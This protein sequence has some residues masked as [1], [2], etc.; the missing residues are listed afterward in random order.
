MITG[1]HCE[2]TESEVMQVLKEMINEIGMDFGSA[3][4]ECPAKP[5]THAFI[6]FMNDGER[7]KFIRSANMLKKEL[8]GRKI[9]ITRSM[10][11][12][13]RFYNKRMGYV[14]YCIHT[15]HNIPLSLISLNWTAKHVSVKGQIVVRTCQSGSLKFS[16][17]Q[18]V[19]EEVE[20]QT[21]KWQT[22]KL[23]ATTVSSE[24]GIRRREEGET[25]SS[26]RM[27]SLQGNQEESRNNPTKVDDDSPTHTRNSRN[28]NDDETKRMEDLRGRGG[29][30]LKH[31][32][33]DGDVPLCLRR[34]Q[35]DDNDDCSSKRKTREEKE[36]GS[37]TQSKTKHCVMNKMASG[38]EDI[39]LR[40]TE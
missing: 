38:S 40:S 26:Q 25:T 29:G 21:Q 8:R 14:K 23:I 28:N 16:K 5:I 9:K 15:R 22:K 10:D 18:D 19:E 27:I 34:N 36:S 32:T 2:T 31:R 37:S 24:K 1:F 39:C 4:I 17:Y 13:E 35:R 6:H 33:V 30:R 12:E 3:R 11:A 20:E 7:N